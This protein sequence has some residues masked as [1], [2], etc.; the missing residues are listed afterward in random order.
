MGHN[1]PCY[2]VDLEFL[3]IKGLWIHCK[4]YE[5]LQDLSQR[6]LNVFFHTDEDYVLTSKNY[7][8]AYPG[9][10]GGKY[11]I[12]VMPEWNDFPTNGFAGICS[13]YI[14]DYKC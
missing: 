13:D 5:A 2:V 1:E 10:L 4:N 7:I 12:C 14:G 8:W 11:T 6:D 3:G 9:K